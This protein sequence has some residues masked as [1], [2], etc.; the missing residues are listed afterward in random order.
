[1]TQIGQYDGAAAADGAALPVTTA[2][3]TATECAPLLSSLFFA[4]GERREGGGV[5]G[6]C[7]SFLSSSRFLRPT[8][9]QDFLIFLWEEGRFSC[10]ET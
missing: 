6:V 5:K 9:I 10:D 4:A 7:P 8:L 2:N 3:E 1:M